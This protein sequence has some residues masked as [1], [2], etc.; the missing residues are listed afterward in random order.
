MR[1]KRVAAFAVA[2]ILL[3]AI[4]LLAVGTRSSTPTSEAG[5]ASGPS[6]IVILFDVDMLRADR[7]GIYGYARPTSPNLDRAMAEGLVAEHAITSAG[8]TLPAHASLFSSQPVSVH[9]VRTALQKVPATVPLLAEILS[10]NGIRCLGIQSGGYVDEGFGFGR[11]FERYLFTTDRVDRKV[12]G[13]LRFV[14]QAGPGPLFLFVHSVQVH[15]F[16]ATERG[17]RAVFGSTDS[18]GPRWTE[19]FSALVEARATYGDAKIASWLSARYDAAVREVDESL[20][21]LIA[22]IQA[23][24]LSDRTALV[25]TSDHGEELGERPL[26]LADSAPARGHTI[27]YL[28]EEHVRIPLALRA[29]WRKELRGRIAQPVSTLDVAPTILD[30]FDVAVPPGMTGVSLGRPKPAGRVVV[31]EASPYGA[32]A[33]F[34]GS[35]KVIVRPGFR[36]RHWE[37]GSWLERLPTRECFDLG[38][39][40]AEKSGTA[41]TEP[42]ARRLL[43]EATRTIAASFPGDFVVRAEPRGGPCR[44]DMGSATESEV[45]FFGAPPDVHVTTAGGTESVDL[46]G[47][48][49]PVW[50]AIQPGGD[51]RALWLHVTGCGDVKTAA[52]NS[53]PPASESG[54]SD[55]LWRGERNLPEGTVVFS[56]APGPRTPRENA[57]YP[58]ELTARLRSLGYVSADRVVPASTRP[59]GPA[60]EG[61]LPPPGRIRI[62]VGL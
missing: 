60:P 27:P 62:R 42:W 29:P 35:H 14:D 1:L 22:G 59:A 41:C 24:G 17:A 33:L 54:W 7:L 49:G 9:G 45:R 20:G 34:E 36:A 3:S 2:T 13:A 15:N 31:S 47:L 18:L 50:L 23:R 8:W 10:A 55:L 6:R 44:L 39:D 12:Q 38:R 16:Q 25:F 5:A 57:N 28:Y 58:P 52:G 46:G 4:A 11:G 51:D 32:I 37:T 48:D 56:V 53:L 30:L 21:E 40:P 61:A 19:P 43:G 26:K